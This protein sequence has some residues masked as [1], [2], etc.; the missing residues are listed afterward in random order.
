[1]AKAAEAF[2]DVE[3][4]VLAGHSFGGVTAMSDTWAYMTSQNSTDEMDM[5][6]GLALLGSYIQDVGCGPI[7]FSEMTFP[8]ASV[9]ASLDGVVNF[10]NFDKGEFFLPANDTFSLNIFGGNHGLFG[11]YNDTL[12]TPILGQSDGKAT[13]SEQV[14]RDL[15]VAAIANVAARSGVPLPVWDREMESKGKVDVKPNS[16]GVEIT[17]ESENKVD[18]EPDSGGVKITQISFALALLLV[19]TLVVPFL[20]N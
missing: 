20:Q 18:V 7:D 15:V 12:R 9:S 17:Q 3:K 6:G 4:W 11:S 16:G 19:S 10:T 13:I 5:F 2:P 14:Q 8:A 1:M